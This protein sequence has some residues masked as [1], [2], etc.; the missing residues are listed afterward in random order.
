MKCEKLEK[1]PFYTNKMPIDQGLGAM[2][3]KKY[4]EGD[5]TICARYMVST[6]VGPHAV[7]LDLYP[8][9][10]KQAKKIIDNNAE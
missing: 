8:N 1:C 6:T 2:Y 3:S 10:V 5:K 9:M 4:C 7:P